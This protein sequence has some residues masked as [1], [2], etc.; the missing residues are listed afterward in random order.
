M[1]RF[2]WPRLIRFGLVTLRLE[3]DVFWA[4]TPAE[5]TLLAGQGQALSPLDRTALEALERAFPDD[6]GDHP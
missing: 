4:L 2:D 1:Q 3:P 5:L 6:I